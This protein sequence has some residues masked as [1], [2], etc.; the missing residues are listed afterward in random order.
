MSL[1]RPK[2]ATALL[3]CVLAV[4]SVPGA[5][6]ASNGA[7]EISFGP[8]GAG[9]GGAETAV[10]DDAVSVASNPSGMAQIPG[11]RA[12]LAVAVVFSRVRFTDENQDELTTGV[13]PIPALGISWDP[14]G[15]PVAPEG[16][17]DGGAGDGFEDGIGPGTSPLRI[18]L[19]IF[20][21]GGSIDENE[22]ETEL[23]PDGFT[24]ETTLFA[25]AI[26]PSVSV[27]I[28]DTLALGA[29]FH[30]YIMRFDLK[31]L[32][33]STKS[34]FG[35]QVLVRN[36]NGVPVDPPVP[37][38]PPPR[39]DLT[40][41]ELFDLVQSGDPNS[42]TIVE[43]DTTHTIGFGGSVG[44]LWQPIPE[45]AFG[46]SYTFQ[47]VFGDLEGDAEV[48]ATR[49]IEE[50]NSNP[51]VEAITGFLFNSFL[52]N[53]GSEGF[54]ADYDYTIEDVSTPAVLA[55]GV[56]VRPVDRLL[57]AL[58]YK[59]IQWSEA[60]DELKVTL[61]NG[62][63]EDINEINGGDRIDR[64]VALD[65]DDQHVIAIGGAFLAADWL[66]I[67]AGYNYGN[68]PVPSETLSPSN[69]GITEHHLALG[70]GFYVGPV[71]L[72]FAYVYAFPNQEEI[73]GNESNPEYNGVEVNAEQHWL[74]FGVGIA[75]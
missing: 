19:Q 65:W 45:L 36:V 52:P 6:L 22:F 29:S 3:L 69:T 75:F 64:D 25:L 60:F 16:G 21:P 26:A 34:K 15:E 7:R 37:P 35:G 48:D 61:E 1:G 67:R 28:L 9:R 13:G 72:D 12:D 38:L 39:D 14:I 42:S 47:G 70:A 31:G 68:N 57:I 30:I 40:F 58:D 62:T 74:Y 20:A 5:A 11:V 27:R 17:G 73:S 51:E 54:V 24:T 66:V 46:A 41:G 59:F 43:F 71:D 2:L 53:G 8:K 55:L 56:A 63:N 32:L 23:F 50:L 49:T 4:A 44:L 18:G 10:V 33:G